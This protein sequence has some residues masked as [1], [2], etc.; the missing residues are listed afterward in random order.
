MMKWIFLFALLLVSGP[1]VPAFLNTEWTILPP[2]VL[3]SV[4]FIT[5]GTT[6]IAF[7]LNNFSLKYVMPITVSIYIY[8]QPV[9]ASVVALILGQDVITLI[10]IFSAILVFT[11]VY[12][13][14]YSSSKSGT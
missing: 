1:G 5:V 7:L 10:K 8:S 9:T 4:L 3:Y 13:V 11:G 6:F 12:F 14:S 2:E